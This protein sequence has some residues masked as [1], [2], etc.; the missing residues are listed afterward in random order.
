[1]RHSKEDSSIDRGGEAPTHAAF[2]L[3][4]LTRAAAAARA[5]LRRR[6]VVTG[7]DMERLIWRIPP[8]CS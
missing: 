5:R 1:M 3:G 2:Q 8:D 7:R 4:N 6:L